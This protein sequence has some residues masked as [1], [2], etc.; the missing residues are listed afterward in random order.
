MN[1]ILPQ[2]KHN[3]LSIECTLKLSDSMVLPILLYGCEIWKFENI[4][5]IHTIH[6]YFVRQV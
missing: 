6:I 3:N 5:I 1:F 4:E 2:I